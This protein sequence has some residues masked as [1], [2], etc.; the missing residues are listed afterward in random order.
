MGIAEDLARLERQLRQLRID[1]E[2]YFAGLE[3]REPV[4]LRDEVAQAIRKYSGTT[5]TKTGHS[6][7]LNS[8]TATFNA[9]SAYWSRVVRQIEE[10]T[11]SRDRFKLKLKEKERRAAETAGTAAAPP[12]ATPTPTPGAARFQEGAEPGARELQTLYEAL[13]SAKRTVGESLDGLAPDKLAAIIKQQLPKITRQF[14]CES[15]EFRVVVEDGRTKLK[16]TPK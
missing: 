11:Y 3:K 1:Y 2:K 7:K 16:A 12:N 8:L 15:V 9:Y 6:F 14:G 10:G 4:E 13:V 5:L